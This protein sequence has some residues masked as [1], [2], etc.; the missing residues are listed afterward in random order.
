MK[1]LLGS[2]ALLVS[3]ITSPTARAQVLTLDQLTYLNGLEQMSQDAYLT[4]RGWKF[5]Q[6]FNKSDSITFVYWR[7]FDKKNAPVG[8]VAVQR[9]V[10]ERDALIYTTFTRAPFEATRNK[11]LDYRMELLGTDNSG[12]AMRTYFRGKRYEVMLSLF[13]DEGVPFYRV[14]VQPHGLVKGFTIGDDG[15]T[16]QE[17]VRLPTPTAE[18]KARWDAMADSLEQVNQRFKRQQVPMKKS[19]K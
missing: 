19:R 10:G 16:T 18:Q 17:W 15:K 2:L 6:V 4:E 1:K 12:G 3:L 7:Y 13:T 8:E 11:V 5:D 9:E 14:R